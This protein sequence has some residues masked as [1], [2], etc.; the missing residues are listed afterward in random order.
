MGM[1]IY[2]ARGT[3]L[4]ADCGCLASLKML[5]PSQNVF[6]RNHTPPSIARH[7]HKMDGTY[8]HNAVYHSTLAASTDSLLKLLL[9]EVILHPPQQGIISRWKGQMYPILYTIVPWQLQQKS[10]FE[11]GRLG[12]WGGG[13]EGKGAGNYWVL[14]C[15]E[16]RDKK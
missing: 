7:H 15:T 4:G 8:I 6:N 12:V 11:E 2:H 5:D 14:G 13:E 3:A 10:Y 16:G 9:T 1:Q